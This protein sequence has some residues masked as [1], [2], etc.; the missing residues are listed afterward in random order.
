M[1]IAMPE[2]T[3]MQS[4]PTIPPPQLEIPFIMIP[5]IR[6]SCIPDWLTHPVRGLFQNRAL[7]SQLFGDSID[8]HVQI[9]A[10]EVPNSGVLMVAR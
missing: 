6:S 2:T 5:M 1:S 7:L 9:V 10:D 8:V 4:A 3:L